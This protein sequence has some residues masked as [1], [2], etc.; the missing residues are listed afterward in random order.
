MSILCLNCFKTSFIKPNVQELLLPNYNT[1]TW[2]DYFALGVMDQVENYI[3]QEEGL[4]QHEYKV[5]SLGIDPSAALLHGFYCVD[6]YSNNYPLE[7]KTAFRQVIAKEIDKSEWLKAYFDDWGNRCYL[8]S[9]ELYGY[10]NVEKNSFWYNSL[11]L[12]TDALKQLGCDYI[13]SAAYIVPAEDISGHG[14][15]VAAI[16][17]GTISGVAPQAEMLVI[18]LGSSGRN[19][20]PLTTQ[21]M[22][23]INFAV[24]TG[25]SDL[26][27]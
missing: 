19:S 15:A 16:A 3:S 17:A 5:A 25:I 13:L 2:S 8:L 23:G 6:G 9:S 10:Y 24:N 11:E 7:Y 22:R 27:S 14:T 4:E 1:I 18:K 26:P 20:F 21:L 12:N